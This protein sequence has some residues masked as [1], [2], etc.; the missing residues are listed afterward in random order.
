[1]QSSFILLGALLALDS[2]VAALSLGHRQHTNKQALGFALYSAGAEAFC[3]WLGSIMGLKLYQKI[4]FM[5]RPLMM[6]L[7]VSVALSFFWDAWKMWE[8]KNK[9]MNPAPW[10]GFNWQMGVV[11]FATS[12]DAMGIGVG[13]GLV[14]QKIWMVLIS[15]FF[16]AFTATLVGLKMSHWLSQTWQIG[17]TLLGGVGLLILGLY[18]TFT[19]V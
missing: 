12:L 15:I 6:V 13:L 11:G 1:M 17:M 16:F 2:F 4:E 7:F 3:A 19:L 10:D 5:T 18:F 8:D 14:G 9:M